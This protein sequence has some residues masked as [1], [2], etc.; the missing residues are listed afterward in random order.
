MQVSVSKLPG[1][2]NPPNLGYLPHPT[3]TFR[4]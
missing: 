3:D 2:E 1:A 4:W